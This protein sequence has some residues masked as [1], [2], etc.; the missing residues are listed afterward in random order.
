M[1]EP[2]VPTFEQLRVL[3]AVVE[4]G[5]FAAAARRLN[6]ATSAITYAIG[7]LEAQLG[8]ALFDRVATRKPELTEV[9]RAVVTEAR[10]VAHGID[11][12]RARVKGLGEGLEAEVS[13]AVD[14][15]LPTTRLV[16]ALRSNPVGDTRSG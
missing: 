10:T 14:V 11:M 16:D 3:I 12:L 15:F 6:G 1:T 13:I 7:N 4:E 5:S 8:I 2:G 9:G